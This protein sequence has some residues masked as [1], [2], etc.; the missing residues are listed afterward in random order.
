[1]TRVDLTSRL[2]DL[3]NAFGLPVQF[4][5][6]KVS[7]ACWSS[8]FEIARIIDNVTHTHLI[9]LDVRLEVVVMCHHLPYLVF[10]LGTIVLVD[11]DVLIGDRTTISGHSKFIIYIKH[12][13]F[14]FG[15]EFLIEHVLFEFLEDFI[16]NL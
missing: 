15:K 2:F 12:D 13:F 7:D 14:E 8:I 5:Q 6:L 11:S 16:V 4:L 3:V 10:T 9:L 1:M